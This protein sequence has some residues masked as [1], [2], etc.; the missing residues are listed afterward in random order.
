[1]TTT[2]GRDT[3]RTHIRTDRSQLGG[4]LEA[5]WQAERDAAATAR[6]RGDAAAE[7]RH[8]ER[9]HILSQPHGRP[10]PAHP[11]APCSRAALRRR[12]GREV[13]RPAAATRCSPRPARS[14]AATRSATP[15]APTS[16]P[17][18]P[19]P[20][21]TT[22][23]RSCSPR[24]C[25]MTTTHDHAPRSRPTRRARR[26]AA[27][28]TIVR[29]RRR[30]HLRPAHRSRRQ[31][32]RRRP[33]V[34]ML[35]YNGSIPGPTLR[36]RQGSE[37]T[38]RVR[39]DGDHETT[40][41][42]H[43]LRLDN[44]YD[45]VPDETQ[46]P[47]PVG[48]EFTYQLRFPDDGLYWYHPHVREDYGLEMGLYGNILVDP[49]DARRGRRSTAKSIVD[50]RR[51]PHRRRPHRAVPHRRPHAHGDGPLRER[52]CSPA[53]PPTSRLDARRRRGRPLLPHQHRQHPHL[54]R[55]PS[56]AAG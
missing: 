37:I 39:N 50:P 19:C 21:P 46:A 29:P 24:R 43:G 41:H 8:L 42:W 55:R 7:W 22:S 35:A 54:Q 26:T 16:A 34:R 27:R 25:R 52:R 51:R 47:I 5:A 4:A 23:A 38:V 3:R 13:A 2:A 30:R 56:P 11:R 1:M 12:D 49:A 53:A 18:G 48:G 6:G 45:G 40:V 14:P 32:A 10:P 17:S 36:V 28:A 31:R 20:S 33:R 9:A 15:A 44:D